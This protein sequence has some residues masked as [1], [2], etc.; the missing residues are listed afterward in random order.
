MQRRASLEDVVLAHRA[1]P[2]V[3]E[4]VVHLLAGAIRAGDEGRVDGDRLP[5][6]GAGEQAQLQHRVRHRRQ[7]FLVADDD[8]MHIGDRRDEFRIAL[9]RDEHHR[10]RLG[11]QRVRATDTEPRG[12]EILPQRAPRRRDLPGNIVRLEVLARRGGE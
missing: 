6:G 8:D 3:H 7:Q 4:D 1:P 10:A 2:V 5:G 12:E 11:D 9:I